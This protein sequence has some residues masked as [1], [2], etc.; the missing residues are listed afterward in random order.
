MQGACGTLACAMAATHTAT[1]PDLIVARPE[2]LYCPA[3]DFFIDP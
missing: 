2:G 1:A 3:G